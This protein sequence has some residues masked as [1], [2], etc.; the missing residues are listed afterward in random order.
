[1]AKNCYQK[2]HDARNGKLQQRN[3]ASSSNQGD[4]QLFVMQRMANSMIGGVSDNNVWYVDSGASNHMTSHGEWFR[5][6]KDL[7]TSRFVETCDDTTHPITQIGKVPLSMQDGQTK[8]LKDVLHVPNITKNLVSVCQMGEQG[9]QVI[10]NPNG[11]FVEDM[12][13]QGKL[14]AKGERNGRM[15][16]LD[17]N[18]PKVNSML[19]THGKGAR[20]IGI[21]HKQVGHV[22]FQRLKLMEKQNFIGGFLKFGTEEVT[23]EVCEACQLGKQTRHPFPVQTT[24]V[25]SKHLE[26]IHS[27]VW[28]T[29]TE[30]IG[31]CKYYVNF[32]Y[33]HTRKVWAQRVGRWQAKKKTQESFQMLSGVQRV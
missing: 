32:I 31:G 8:Y 16:T 29:K 22:N 12:K 27:N 26:V 4:E 9:L 17:V 14:I 33:D 1:M 30:S 28:I 24:H 23:S 19:F 18:M 13:N 2:E 7:K 21:W 3:Y 11:C 15:F 10:F 25:S 5:D 20:D 6:T